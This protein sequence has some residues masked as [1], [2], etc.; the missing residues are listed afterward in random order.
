MTCQCPKGFRWLK[1]HPKPGVG[2]LKGDKFGKGRSDFNVLQ[3]SKSIKKKVQILYNLIG[4]LGR[5]DDR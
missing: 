2:K 3:R 4:R 5:R 1:S